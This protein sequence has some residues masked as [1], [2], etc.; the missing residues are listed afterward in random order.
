MGRDHLASYVVKNVSVTEL[1]FQLCFHMALYPKQKH[2][3]NTY[4]TKP[5][6]NLTSSVRTEF[7]V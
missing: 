5:W 4:S 3:S 1:T 7:T 6:A 2:G